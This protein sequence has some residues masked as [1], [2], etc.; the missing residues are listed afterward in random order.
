M[1]KSSESHREPHSLL[2]KTTQAGMQ[3]AA[4]FGKQ[5][6]TCAGMQDATRAGMQ[7]VECAGMQDATC[8]GAQ[9]VQ[10]T[11]ASLPNALQDSHGISRRAFLHGASAVAAGVALSSIG[12]SL[13]S[14]KALAA[15]EDEGDPQAE[16]ANASDSAATSKLS[17]VDTISTQLGSIAVLSVDKDMVFTTEDCNFV[18]K[19][20]KAAKRVARAHLPYGSLVW[21][22]DNDIAACLLPC[23]TSK[24]LTNIALLSLSTGDLHTVRESAVGEKDGFHIYDVRANS[25]GAVWVEANILESKWRVYTAKVLSNGKKLG[26]AALVEEGDGEWTMPSL[27]V[28]GDYAFWQLVPAPDASASS[29]TSMLIRVKF[30][31]KK[32]DTK[33]VYEAP[34]RM[35]CAPTPSE[36]GIVIAPRANLEEGSG[37]YY[38]LTYIDAAS[39]V[40]ESA[41]ALPSSMKPN[42]VSYGP[43]GF[44]FAFESIYNYGDGISNLGTYVSSENTAAGEPFGEWFRFPRSPFTSPAW[45][46]NWFIV[47]STSVVAGVDLANRRYFSIEPEYALQGYGE[48]LASEGPLDRIVTYSNIDYTPIGGDHIR[49]CNVRIWESA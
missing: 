38:Q 24:P 49:E 32:E 5:D 45:M 40:V 23:E 13:A 20:S 22:S 43:T 42:Y 12:Y 26:K 27:A 28:S 31:D 29:L 21:A 36:D 33:C 19:T 25:Q 11:A 47:K 1:T 16:D 7:D 15:P 8:T 3:D 6:A 30:G 4:Y 44:S 39:G 2:A 34:G 9:G 41:L 17:G 10:C 14:E 48:Y 46:N 35:A 18:K 37:S